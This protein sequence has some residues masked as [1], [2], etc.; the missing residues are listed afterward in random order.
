L[1]VGTSGVFERIWFLLLFVVLSD[2]TPPAVTS[3]MTSSAGRAST[4]AEETAA[5]TRRKRTSRNGER[6]ADGI[7]RDAQVKMARRHNNIAGVEEER[8][9]GRAGCTTP[10]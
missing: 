7:G 6:D 3:A 9:E 2:V 4:S 5:R 8:T 10:R 1:E